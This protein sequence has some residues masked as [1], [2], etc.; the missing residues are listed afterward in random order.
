MTKEELL[1]RSETFLRGFFEKG[2]PVEDL[3]AGADPVDFS[4]IGPGE[5]EFFDRAEGDQAVLNAAAENDKKVLE[6]AAD[7]DQKVLEAAVA[8]D[9]AIQE[10]LGGQI[11]KAKQ[12][13]D[14]VDGELQQEKIDRAEED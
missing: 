8:N 1:E 10:Q 11:D 9:K 7:N 6:A 4:W 3:L 13:I 12:K 14:T 5:K 2:L